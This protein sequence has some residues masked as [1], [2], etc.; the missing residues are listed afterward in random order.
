[1]HLNS[2][3][4]GGLCIYKETSP[5]QPVME[6]VAAAPPVEEDDIGSRSKRNPSSRVL[7]ETEK[8]AIHGGQFW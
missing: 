6:D 3:Q 7:T 2:M 8:R 1:M 4:A 5:P